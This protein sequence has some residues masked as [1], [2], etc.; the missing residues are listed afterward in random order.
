MF[1][2]EYITKNLDSEEKL[3]L[4]DLKIIYENYYDQK[5]TNMSRHSFSSVKR[6]LSMFGYNISDS[7][8]ELKAA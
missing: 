3:N 8:I 6:L 1:T 4:A 7:E 5:I 2:H